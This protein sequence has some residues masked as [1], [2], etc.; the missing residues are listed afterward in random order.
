MNL[1]RDAPLQN[2]QLE[3]PAKFQIKVNKLVFYRVQK[4]SGLWH[5]EVR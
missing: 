5:M 4:L 2:A 1:I 3:V